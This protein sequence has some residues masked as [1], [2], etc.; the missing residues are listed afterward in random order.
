MMKLDLREIPVLY[1]NLDRDIEKRKNIEKFLVES[2]FKHII[3]VPGV[4]HPTGNKGGCSMAQHNALCE[5]EPPFIIFEDDIVPNNFNPIISIPDDSD[6][7]YLGISSWG[8]MNSHSGPFVQYEKIDENIL[9]VYNMLGT[10]AILYLSKEYVSVSK[11][12]SYH[13]YL[14][15]DYIDIGFTDIQKYYN[16]YTFDNPMFYQSSSNGTNNKL[17]SYPTEECFNYN[18]Y[19]WLPSKVY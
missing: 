1:I 8:R 4:V 17:T 2:G 5:I 16:V 9:R 6:V 3:R 19:Y 7:F 11:K 18:R 15:E 14:I 10:H 13:Q 12:I